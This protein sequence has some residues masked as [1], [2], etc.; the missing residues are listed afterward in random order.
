MFNSLSKHINLLGLLSKRKKTWK[1]EI[2]RLSKKFVQMRNKDELDNP[3]PLEN[4]MV[5]HFGTFKRKKEFQLPAVG[6]R[7]RSI[8]FRKQSTQRVFPWLSELLKTGKK[9]R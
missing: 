8:I 3:E 5:K 6:E 4:R 2:Q 9:K 7:Q 1:Q